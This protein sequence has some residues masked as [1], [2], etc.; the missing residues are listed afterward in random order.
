MRDFIEEY[1]KRLKKAIAAERT[2]RE[3]AV[4]S[5]KMSDGAAVGRRGEARG[6]P[7]AAARSSPATFSKPPSC[8]QWA[9]SGTTTPA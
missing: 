9:T 6:E 5:L 4:V 7:S 2:N 3:A 8:R 1:K